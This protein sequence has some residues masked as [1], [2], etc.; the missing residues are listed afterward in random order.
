MSKQTME[1]GNH[2]ISFEELSA[3]KLLLEE[4]K[5][6]LKQEFVGIDNV[7]N[8]VI[9]AIEAWYIFPEGQI[10]PTVINLFGMTGVGKTSLVSRLCDLIK[11]EQKL[12]RFDFGYYAV[13]DTKLKYDFSNNLSICEYLPVVLMFDEFQLGRTIDERGGEVDRLGLRALW[14]LLDSGKIAILNENYYTHKVISLILKLQH[15]IEN[16]VE[17]KNGLITKNQKFHNNIF[18]TSK[19]TGK[20]IKLENED[21]DTVSDPFNFVPED[22]LYGIRQILKEKEQALGSNAFIRQRLSKMNHLETIKFLAGLLDTHLQPT[23]H[24]FS[25]SLIFVIGNLDEVYDMAGAIDPDCDA[26]IFYENSLKITTTDVK[27]ALKQRF[28]IEQIARLGNNHIVYP[29]FSS[30]AYKQLIAIELKKFKIRAQERYGIEIELDDS[31]QSILYREGVFPTQGTRPVFT[32]INTL[33]ESYVSKIMSDIVLSQITATKI[34]WKFN[35]DTNEYEVKIFSDKKYITKQYGLNLKVDNLRK[36]TKDD[37]QAHTAV[38][39]AGHAVVACMLLGI[40][41]EETVSKTAGSNLGYCRVQLPGVLT[42]EVMKKDISVGLGGY[43]AERI[44]FGNEDLSFGASDDIQKVTERAIA[45]VKF[46][47]MQGEPIAIGVESFNMNHSHVFE[48]GESNKIVKNIV[49]ECLGKTEA[50][51]KKHKVLLLKISEYL[52][53][54]SRIDKTL[55][56]DFVKKY[57][58]STTKIREP[59]NYYDFRHKLQQELKKTIKKRNKTTIKTVK[60]KKQ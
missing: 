21:G 33:I 11:M 15:C 9:H 1:L 56:R 40:I 24:D 49:M 53:E 37:T 26:D 38:H 17:A 22:M 39:E 4:A 36:S 8:E 51:L 59:E 54:N 42:R 29:A 6:V 30:S 5:K 32:T 57:A 43:A 28:R 52:S 19:Q 13:E 55:M 58:V 50:I 25:Q 31:V 3:K 46:Y 18:Y 41:P 35:E 7:I 23:I 44:I 60:T 16:D 48:D 34:Q 47:G 45:F 20:R 2:S 10:R 14:D 12:F 27:E